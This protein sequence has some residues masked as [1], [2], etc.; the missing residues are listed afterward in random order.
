MVKRRQ[1]SPLDY[2]SLPSLR[3]NPDVKKNIL[4]VLFFLVAIILFLS[5]FD[6]AGSIGP[7]LNSA[8]AFLAGWAKWMIPILLLIMGFLLFGQNKKKLGALH[9]IGVLLFLWSVAAVLQFLVE[10]AD[11]SLALDQGKGGGYIGWSLAAMVMKAFGFWAGFIV[12]LALL[13]IGLMLMFNSTLVDIFQKGTAPIRLA[14]HPLAFLFRKIKENNLAKQYDKEFLP[15]E[16]LP[17]VEDFNVE[18][19]VTEDTFVAHPIKGDK[20]RQ[21]KKTAVADEGSRWHQT[22]IKID[23]PLDLLNSRISKPTSGD[24]KAN[25][26]IIRMTLEKFGI[27][28]E[29]GEISVG[30]TVT[31]YTLKPAEGIKLSRITA[32]NNDLSM[33]LAAHPVRIEAPIP[34][35]ALV[36]I[37]VPNKTAATVPLKEILDSD[38]FKKRKVNLMIGLGKDVAG[39]VWLDNLAKMPHMLVAGQ[40]GSGKSVML[41][42]MIISLL[43]QNN[44]DD[45]RFI[46]VDPKRVELTIYNGLPHLLTPVITEVSKTI[47]ALKW[48]LNEMDRR[49]DT[50]SK[51]HKRDIESYNENTKDKMP[52]IVFII[53]EL[54]DL[55]VVAG[56]DMEAGIVRLAQMARAVGIHLVLATQRPSVNVI[57]GTIKAN[58]PARIAFAVASGIDSR[59]ILDSSGAEKL[60][61]RGDMLF[62]NA[63]LSKP[64]RLQ[65]ALITDQEIKRVVNYIKDKVGEPNY[66]E[67]ITERQKVKGMAGVGIDGGSDDDDELL[68]EAKELIINSGKASASYLQRRLSIGYARAARLLD[69]LE[70]AGVIGPSNGAKAREIMISQEQYASII[71]QGVSGTRLHN[72]AESVAPDE[73][74]PSEDEAEDDDSPESSFS[75]ES[76]DSAGRDIFSDMPEEEEEIVITEETINNA[77]VD[78][79]HGVNLS[80]TSSEDEETSENTKKKPK[81]DDSDDD[82]GRYFSR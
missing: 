77:A 5:L 69:L 16:I 13:F 53:D 3:V 9:Y 30:P 2:I 35:K 54:A 14:F 81:N 63:T 68:S 62:S 39:Q 23:L 21:S 52:Y 49:F 19:N 34:G 10:P 70:E 37:E 61:G 28:V 55:M 50:L 4:V 46:M 74:L 6:L 76:A 79:R 58:M 20:V 12:L 72:Q 40:T 56:K 43:Y 65:G 11:W 75:A 32:L 41:N 59:T 31:Q 57:T 51:L 45:L 15:D 36:G 60:L 24:I 47:N 73:Y 71:D 82:F 17:P 42:T 26:E 44:P 66:L 8:L 67:E 22:N 80:E 78:S 29:M 1:K 48:C 33:A 27:P 18:N 38:N 25:T 7:Y 64:K